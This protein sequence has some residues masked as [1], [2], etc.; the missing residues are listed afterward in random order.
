MRPGREVISTMKLHNKRIPISSANYK[1]EII[2]DLAETTG[3]AGECHMLEYIIRIDGTL[4]GREFF[5]TLCH[6]IRHAHHHETGMSEILDHQAMEM[7]CQ[8]F[9][10]LLWSLMPMLSALYKTS[11]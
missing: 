9:A 7:D 4:E 8:S 6:E 11:K 3:H 1:I 2:P 5:K 10:T